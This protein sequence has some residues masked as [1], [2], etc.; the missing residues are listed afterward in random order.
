L[1]PSNVCPPSVSADTLAVSV[2]AKSTILVAESI[3]VP[4]V[5]ITTSSIISTWEGLPS[6]LLPVLSK[7]QPS[8][9]GKSLPQKQRGRKS[10]R[11]VLVGQAGR[12][13]GRS[14]HESI[15]DGRGPQRVQRRL[16]GHVLSWQAKSLSR[17]LLPH[18]DAILSQGE[19]EQRWAHRH[20]HKDAPSL[21][22]GKMDDGQ[23]G[24]LL[25]LLERRGGFPPLE[26]S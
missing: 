19:K 16:R 11:T 6:F 24:K 26:L 20:R 17:G 8:S 7:R 5:A 15:S 13:W 2:F 23:N 3:G 10:E 22:Q 1:P 9:R 18:P 25:L 4:T 21:K 14:S 12:Q